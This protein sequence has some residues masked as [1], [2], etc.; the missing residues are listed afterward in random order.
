MTSNG[1]TTYWV[2]WVQPGHVMETRKDYKNIKSYKKAVNI[3]YDVKQST[4]EGTDIRLVRQRMEY[5]HMPPT[6]TESR[7]RFRKR[8]KIE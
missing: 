4:P 1:D 2:Y 6:D 8:K 3:F 7:D 5:T